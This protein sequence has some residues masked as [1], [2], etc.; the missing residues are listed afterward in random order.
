MQILMYFFVKKYSTSVSFRPQ[1]GLK[2]YFFVHKLTKYFFYGGIETR[3][4]TSYY[5]TN[6]N[7]SPATRAISQ[8]SPRKI[9]SSQHA[10]ATKLLG[11]E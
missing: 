7:V 5:S 4:S 3:F 1:M 8:Y 11:G 2:P 6:P 10:G 9:H